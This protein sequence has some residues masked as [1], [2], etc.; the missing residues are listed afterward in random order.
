MNIFVVV[1]SANSFFCVYSDREFLSPAFEILFK[2]FSWLLT[3]EFPL[4]TSNYFQFT[5]PTLYS[6]DCITR[7]AML[8]SFSQH[9]YNAVKGAVI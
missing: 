2:F 5:S 4:Y 7:H 6:K 9:I 8:P 3:N 1:V